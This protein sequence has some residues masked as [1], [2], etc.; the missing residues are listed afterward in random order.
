METTK[1]DP[2]KKFSLRLEAVSE[3][4]S[5]I[6]TEIDSGSSYYILLDHV[7]T[8]LG[9]TAVALSIRT[10]FSTLEPVARL[11]FKT[12][13]G[14]R[15]LESETASMAQRVLD[16]R[17]II[18]YNRSSMNTVTD[19]FRGFMDQEDFYDYLGMPLVEGKQLLGVLEMF[20]TQ[21]LNTTLDW[22]MHLRF[23]R[24]LAANT[25]RRKTLADQQKHTATEL[26]IAY[27]ETLEAWVRALEIRD[28]YTAGHTQR[29]LDLTLR[30]AT[31]M[32]IPN[33]MLIH[34]TRGVL[35]HDIGKLAISDNIL[36]KTGPLD[37]QEWAAMREHPVFAYNL[38]KPIQYLQPALDIPYCH[39]EKWDGSGYPQ[40]LQG[41]SIPYPARIF[42][43]VD[44][45]DALTTDR[46]YRKAWPKDD[47]L[48]Y[49]QAKSGTEFDPK[50]VDEFVGL[51]SSSTESAT[52]PI[53]VHAG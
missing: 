30:L 34:I 15:F 12:S 24:S 26:E 8:Q 43:V 42:S 41:P 31:K 6:N 39:H 33:E 16:S 25:I 11:G 29:V 32:G 9:V 46:P 37:S 38:L 18:R 50:V 52:Q 48:N 13:E 22:R 35:L 19:A 1:K 14:V 23:I 45:W 44:V 49:I 51:M 36:R 10:S 47:A 5:D 27:S 40:G 53:Y 4:L 21:P 20:C 17:Q 3:I 28:Q 7:T 2:C